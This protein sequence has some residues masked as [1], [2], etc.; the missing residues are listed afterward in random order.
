[1]QLDVVIIRFLTKAGSYS[2]LIAISGFVGAHFGSFAGMAI[3]AVTRDSDWVT[4]GRCAGWTFLVL[5]AVIGAPFDYVYFV[6]GHS[7][8]HRA[9]SRKRGWEDAEEKPQE[10]ERTVRGLK[11]VPAVLL[12][13]AAGGLI[14]GGILCGYLV[15]VYFFVALSPWGPR[16]WWPVLPLS[17]KSTGGGSSSEN[18]I[19]VAIALGSLGTCVLLGIVI[20]LSGA[21]FFGKTRYQ[22]FGSGND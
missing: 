9:I 19:A 6:T 16:G 4:H 18:P 11:A 13:G 20:G 15:A 21:T 5:F 10:F 12:I 1:M 8:K 3:A 14:V 2:L 17:F 22:V 7:L